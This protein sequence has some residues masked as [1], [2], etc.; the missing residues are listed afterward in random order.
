MVAL[1]NRGPLY[2]SPVSTLFRLSLR[3][4]AILAVAELSLPPVTVKFDV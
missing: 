4:A 2:F 1:Y 3:H